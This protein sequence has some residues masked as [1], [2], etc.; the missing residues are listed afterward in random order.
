MFYFI[1]KIHTMGSTLFLEFFC[2][3]CMNLTTLRL[4]HTTLAL[5]CRLDRI[6]LSYHIMLYCHK[7][8]ANVIASSEQVIKQCLNI[9]FGHMDLRYTYVP[10]FLEI[11]FIHVCLSRL[12]KEM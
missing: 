11:G 4:V 7:I 1:L 5:T 8:D 2:L 12:Y 10:S 6:D 3:K 9:S